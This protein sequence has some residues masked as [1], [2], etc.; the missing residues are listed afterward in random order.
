MFGNFSNIIFKK[1]FKFFLNKTQ[2]PNN[3][4]RTR[5]RQTLF[6]IY[7][8]INNESEFEKI[9]QKNLT[10]ARLYIKY[11]LFSNF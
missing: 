3:D 9:I 2:D 11:F 7:N 8:Y 5:A 1:K 4:A 6:A 10:A